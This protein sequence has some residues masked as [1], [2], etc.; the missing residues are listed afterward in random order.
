M[1]HSLHLVSRSMPHWIAWR[2]VHPRHSTLDLVDGSQQSGRRLQK[3]SRKIWFQFSKMS[4]LQCAHWINQLFD[5]TCQLKSLH[6]LLQS[7]INQEHYRRSRSRNE[8]LAAAREEF[9]CECTLGWY[10][11]QYIIQHRIQVLGRSLN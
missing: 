2:I 6:P 5:D 11:T 9:F 10:T 3:R 4:D 7:D 8:T 1:V